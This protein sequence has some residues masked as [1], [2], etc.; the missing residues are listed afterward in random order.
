M[1][2]IH[3]MKKQTI[4]LLSLLFY[5]SPAIFAQQTHCEMLYERYKDKVKEIKRYRD[6][7]INDNNYPDPP[8][9]DP[10]C[11]YPYDEQA[12]NDW[13]ENRFEEEFKLIRE[14]I[15]LYKDLYDQRC[16]QYDSGSFEHCYPA[17]EIVSHKIYYYLNKFGL[18]E[19]KYR[20]VVR[21]AIYG[22]K[23]IEMLD[24]GDFIVSQNKAYYK[25]K[26]SD[27]Y[28][29]VVSKIQDILLFQLDNTIYRIRQYHIYRAAGI[30]EL[31]RM[32]KQSALLGAL[33]GN[34][35]YYIY[36]LNKDAI[37]RGLQFKMEVT[38][39]AT[40]YNE[41]GGKKMEYNTQGD[42]LLKLDSTLLF[43]YLK[44]KW[45]PETIP[46][47][48]TSRQY[49]PQDGESLTWTSGTEYK[50]KLTAKIDPHCPPAAVNGG[51]APVNPPEVYLNFSN[52]GPDFESY[53][54]VAGNADPPCGAHKTVL[55]TPLNPGVISYVQ[56]FSDCH[57]HTENGSGFLK[58]LIM[59]GLLE[60][61]RNQMDTS[62]EAI[63]NKYSNMR[64]IPLDS[65]KSENYVKEAMRE[66]QDVASFKFTEMLP[67]GNP[68]P[69]DRTIVAESTP[70]D[71]S[72]TKVILHIKL[73]H[74]PEMKL[75]KRLDKRV[76]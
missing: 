18:S 42:C 39:Q 6:A 72:L 58:G 30:Q 34:D 23:H 64:N 69:V 66:I 12:Y 50:A 40:Q 53:D 10:D 22:L 3:A 45:L 62:T 28:T 36:R 14:H 17:L 49:F 59:S 24:A 61:T 55:P 33:D 67:I 44:W 20:N 37:Y 74:T 29:D 71:G 2:I 35:G 56:T 4:V 76:H 41:E 51:P 57:S 52:L 43:D 60:Y 8:D 21:L 70:E 26:K 75:E 16:P 25:Y 32:L 13:L 38:I 1:Q 5:F 15:G 31:Y 11:D 73:S 19:Y 54:M 68:V 9:N 65:F 48:I 46:M 63:K 27:H 7:H 47:K